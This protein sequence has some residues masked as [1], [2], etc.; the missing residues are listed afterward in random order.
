MKSVFFN[1]KLYEQWNAFADSSDEAWFWHTIEWM[2]YAI[3][4]SAGNFA[5]NKSFFIEENSEIQAI[6]P[7]FIEKRHFNGQ[8]YKQ[9]SYAGEPM[10]AL[11]IKNNIKPTKKQEIIKFYLEKLKE[12]ALKESIAFV[13]L[14][15]PSLAEAFLNSVPPIANPFIRYGYIDLP[16]QTQIID[17]R[18][19]LEVLWDE[20]RK[21]H[22]SDIKKA[23]GMVRI[24]IWNF[25]DITRDK[26]AQYQDL[27]RKDA[28]RVTRSQKTFDMMFSWIKAGTAILAEAVFNNKPIGFS[29]MIIYKKGAYYG[30]ACTDPSSGN[31]S[32]S[33]LIQWETIKYL[34]AHGVS[35]YDIG[36]QYYCPEWFQFP[37]DKVVNISKFKR[38]FGG[39]AV[40]MITSE[41]YFSNDLMRGIFLGRMNDNF[42]FG[43][44][45][46]TGAAARVSTDE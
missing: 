41:N 18:K 29:L 2:N 15:M 37:S 1:K 8:H 34:K 23:A 16:Y 19:N 33:H 10:P 46:S 3:E 25:G 17:L 36:L 39:S 5:Q 13:S 4:Y 30:S 12:I 22:K 28:G 26:F 27:H 9:F 20:V 40:P 31:L 45:V 14:R 7:V 11:A 38:G 44:Q 42:H 32:A 43:F 6:C 35:F 24:N 21:G